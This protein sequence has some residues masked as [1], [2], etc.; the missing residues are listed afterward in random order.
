M[1]R[2]EAIPSLKFPADRIDRRR[3]GETWSAAGFNLALP[4][5]LFYA[6]ALNCF[7]V[8]DF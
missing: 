3:C 5:E 4:P 6:A 2:A 8:R 1:A 7:T